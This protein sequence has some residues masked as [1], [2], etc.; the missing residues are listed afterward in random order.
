ML[1]FIVLD[2]VAMGLVIMELAVVREGLG[3]HCLES[4]RVVE[5]E[6]VRGQ[7]QSLVELVKSNS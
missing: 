5:K 1:E 7:V 6:V 3:V 4:R 2:S